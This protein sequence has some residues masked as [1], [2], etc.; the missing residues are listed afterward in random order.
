MQFRAQLLLSC[1]LWTASQAFAPRWAGVAPTAARR[2]APPRPLRE[3]IIDVESEN[4]DV[5]GEIDAAL[6]AT[7]A[8]A[9]ADATLAAADALM[10]GLQTADDGRKLD[11]LVKAT[12]LDHR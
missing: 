11:D 1:F 6:G 4:P 10:N 12:T 5:D 2:S 9:Q 3:R 8:Q 7:P